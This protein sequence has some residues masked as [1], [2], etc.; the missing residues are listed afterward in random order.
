MRSVIENEGYVNYRHLSLL[1][2][3]MTVRGYLT[4]IT[5][6]GVNKGEKSAL[7]RCSFE[8]TVEILLEAALIAEK[9]Q[10]KEVTDS[11][12]LGQVVPIGTGCI[13]L[14]L[15]AEMLKNAVPL[16]QKSDYTFDFEKGEYGTPSI[17]T[18][19]SEEQGSYSGVFSPVRENEIVRSNTMYS[20]SGSLSP[21]RGSYSPL[22]DAYS[23]TNTTYS[24]L[25]DTLSSTNNAYSPLKDSYSPNNTMFNSQSNNLPS[26]KPLYSPTKSYVPQSPTL[27]NSYMPKA[28][29]NNY[30]PTSFAYNPTSPS[31]S[32]T[33]IGYKPTSPG[34]SPQS[35]SYSVMSPSYM[36]F[37][38]SNKNKNKKKDEEPEKE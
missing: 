38:K 29:Q 2:D 18:P 37:S 6:H 14:Y 13:E 7:M 3:V 1:S 34:Y 23:G 25:R 27:V 17:M 19:V 36:S 30:Q 31:F 35:P 26:R 9:S 8:E 15:N 20:P 21:M 32:P 24:P 28:N 12:I 33:N 10:S 5:R 4:G 16:A 11:I 22:R